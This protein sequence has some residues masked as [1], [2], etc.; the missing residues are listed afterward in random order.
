[1]YVLLALLVPSRLLYPIPLSWNLNIPFLFFFRFGDEPWSDEDEGVP[2]LLPLSS[3][4]NFPCFFSSCSC[5]LSIIRTLVGLFHLN[6]L[7]ITGCLV[8]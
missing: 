6:L 7:L 8:D 1:M 4:L 2:V 5:F 3:Y